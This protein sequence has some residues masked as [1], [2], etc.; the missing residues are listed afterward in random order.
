MQ[1]ACVVHNLDSI[2]SCDKQCSFSEPLKFYNV[3]IVA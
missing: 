1:Q 2:I 3:L